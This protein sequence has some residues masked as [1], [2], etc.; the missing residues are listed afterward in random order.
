MLSPNP[1]PDKFSLKL[2]V[3][4]FI[5]KISE[6]YNR[7]IKL[8]NSYFHDISQLINES[9]MRVEIPGL[10]QELKSQTTSTGTSS[11][12]AVGSQDVTLYPDSRP[13][14]EIIESNTINI[15]FRHLDSYINYFY[16]ME[17][18][19]HMYLG[20]QKENRFIIPVT[21]L[22]SDN[23]P[24][25]NV[26]YSQCIFKTMPGMSLLYDNQSRDFKEFTCSFGYSNM[27]VDFD[28]PQG[29][30]KTYK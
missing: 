29:L 30:A 6:K 21:C 17:L 3:N 27:E 24:V 12:G 9:I 28:L 26:T 1:R 4:F 8:Q 10:D 13:L 7:Y 25:F 5:P 15:T 14:E 11:N 16:L 18:W 23:F 19:Y 2:P 22:N 20:N